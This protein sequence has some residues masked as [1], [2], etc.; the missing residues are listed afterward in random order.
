MGERDELAGADSDAQWDTIAIY[1]QILAANP[2]DVDA[3]SELFRACLAVGESARAYGYGVS[4]G[5]AALKVGDPALVQSAH[6]ALS[7]HAA[8]DASLR[9]VVRDLV[10]SLGI[11]SEPTGTVAAAE[12]VAPAPEAVDTGAASMIALVSRIL[13]NMPDDRESLEV[14]ATAYLKLGDGVQ[15]ANSFS[16]LADVLIRDQDREEGAAVLEKLEA[17]KQ[18]APEAAQAAGRLAQFLKPPLE[19][20]GSV[21][22]VSVDNPEPVQAARVVPPS[23]VIDASR[24]RAVLADEMEL[25]WDLQQQG[26]ITEVQYAGVVRDL[27]ELTSSDSITTI[28]AL[29]GLS[30]R[31][32]AGLDALLIQLAAKVAMPVITLGGFDLQ[33]S[34]FGALPLDYLTFQGVIPFEKL[35]GEALVAILNPFSQR[36]RRELAAALGCPCHFFLIPPADFDIALEVVKNRYKAAAEG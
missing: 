2:A 13:E 30:F 29:H 25:L 21:G 9:A 16:R 23:L 6:G 35:G 8:A 20:Q 34:V 24:R 33:P 28:S 4:L 17:L 5:R 31:G 7:P 19:K 11:A 12:G 18:V 22:S 36:L 3:L 14:L 1:E 32:F 10:A 26:L 27:T 15:A